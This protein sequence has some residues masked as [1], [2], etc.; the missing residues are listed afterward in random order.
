LVAVH[1]KDK[2][3]INVISKFSYP[4]ITEIKNS[5]KKLKLNKLHALLI[6]NPDFVFN[7]NLSDKIINNYLL[8]IKKKCNYVGA[9]FNFPLELIKFK[10]IRVAKLY[11]IPFNILDRR[12]NN[13]LSKKKPNEKIYVRSIFLQGL[14]LSENINVCPK[15]IRSEF[16]R[17][18]AKLLKIVKRLDRFDIKDLLISYVNY[19]KKIDKIIIGIDNIDQLRQLPFYFLRKN[20][21]EWFKRVQQ[22]NANAERFNKTFPDAFKQLYGFDEKQ[23]KKDDKAKPKSNIKP[24]LNICAMCCKGPRASFYKCEDVNSDYFLDSDFLKC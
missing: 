16:K 21:T 23:T 24:V 14:L 2:Y 5:L 12:W 7:Q 13:I 19:F 10:K 17:I 8:N 1:Y 9:S 15:K 6:H 18:K 22:E 11:Q 4:Q 3:A 20:P